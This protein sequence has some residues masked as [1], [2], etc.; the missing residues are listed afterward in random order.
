MP[1]LTLN[2]PK[3]LSH[4]HLH[5]GGLCFQQSLKNSFFHKGFWKEFFLEPLVLQ[6]TLENPFL[7]VRVVSEAKS[8]SPR[9]LLEP[10]FLRVYQNSR[11][12][13][14][15][16]EQVWENPQSSTLPGHINC[17][18]LVLIPSSLHRNRHRHKHLNKQERP[19]LPLLS[20]QHQA[21]LVSLKTASLWHRSCHDCHHLHI[22]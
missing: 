12:R 22:T 16:N 9:I 14:H 7:Q 10:L 5:K 13:W 18:S 2:Y 15:N 21:G 17:L 11:N 20:R 4:S 8:H 3:C 6:R 19:F 1:V